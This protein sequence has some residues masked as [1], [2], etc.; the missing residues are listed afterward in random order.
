MSK[1]QDLVHG[2]KYQSGVNHPINVKFAKILD[3]CNAALIESNVVDFKGTSDRLQ[4][5]IDDA[6]SEF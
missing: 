1:S 3:L 2:V 6:D 4:N 5:V